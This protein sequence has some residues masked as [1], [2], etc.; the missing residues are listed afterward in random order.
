MKQTGYHL[1]RQVSW[2]SIIVNLLLSFFKF[3][4]GI[5]AHSNA[6]I[7]DAVHSASD[8]LTTFVVLIG[9]KVASKDADDDHPY[10]H[11][12]LESIAGIILSIFL[13]G[14]GLVIGY[15]GIQKIVLGID[16][17][18]AAPGALALVAALTSIL[19]KEAMYWYTRW[20]AKK[21]S[22]TALMADAWHHRSDA[23]SSVGSLIGIGGAMLGFPIMDPIA[24]LVICLFILYAAYSVMKDAMNRLVD[25]ACDDKTIREIEQQILAVEGVMS[26]DL[27]RSRIFGNRIYLDVEIGCDSTLKL[28]ESHDIAEKVH[29]RIEEAFSDVKHI[30]VHV[31]PHIK[32]TKTDID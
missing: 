26:V 23:L 31:N 3:I 19:V 8:V 12:R 30:H 25:K 10:G 27:I 9:V 1:V 21:T 17:T 7:S 20:A 4:A 15:A 24:S 32:Q 29:D 22:S 5:F 2:I 6:M 28:M 18:L 13:G 14:T 16:G 11:E